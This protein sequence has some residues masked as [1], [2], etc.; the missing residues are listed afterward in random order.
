MDELTSADVGLQAGGADSAP[1]GPV[2]YHHVFSDSSL[3]IGIFVIPPGGCIPLHDHPGMTV[4]SKLLFGSL[5]V[6]SYDMPANGGPSERPSVFD[7]LRGFGGS[8][9][10]RRLLC[11]PP[12]VR[13]VSAPCATLRLDAVEGNI[14]AFEALEHTA[15]FDVLTPPYDSA[16]GRACHYYEEVE[17]EEQG[18]G[19]VVELL[20][21]PWPDSLDVVNRPYAGERVALTG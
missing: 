12:T 5:R 18:G 11:A 10:D 1:G 21:V 17:V 8:G 4:L 20:E 3:S 6:T 2:C 13:V 14:H 16:A 19:E 15:I 9:G 7:T